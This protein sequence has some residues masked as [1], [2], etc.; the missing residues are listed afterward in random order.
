MCIPCLCCMPSR[1]VYSPQ[2][3]HRP[4]APAGHPDKPGPP[5]LGLFQHGGGRVGLYG[6]SNCLDSSHTR[7]HCFQ[8]L[9]KLLTWAAGGVSRGLGKM[10]TAARLSGSAGS[11]RTR[12]WLAGSHHAAPQSLPPARPPVAQEVPQLTPAAAQL[13]APLGNFEGM[14]PR[15]SDYNFT[16][17]RLLSAAQ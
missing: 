10:P 14:P 12:H 15:R 11:R 13:A 7:G 4:P 2:R 1:L 9:S 6:D 5:V 16:E 3:R 8:L 17:A